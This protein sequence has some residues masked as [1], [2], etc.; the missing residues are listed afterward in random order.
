MTTP[1]PLSDEDLKDIALYLSK[2]DA[3]N[4]VDALRLLDEHARLKARVSD[5]ELL[6]GIAGK[7]EQTF[8]APG[9]GVSV[10]VAEGSACH[11]RGPDLTQVSTCPACHVSSW[12]TTLF[13]HE[14]GCQSPGAKLEQMRNMVHSTLVSMDGPTVTIQRIRELLSPDASTTETKR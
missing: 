12:P 5:M 9:G 8:G 7:Q 3:L 2:G 10:D 1:E 6:S 11:P 14:I 4:S 13:K